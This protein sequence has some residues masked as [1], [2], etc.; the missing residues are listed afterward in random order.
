MELE[1]VEAIED[2]RIV[3]V[4]E[5]YARREGLFILRKVSGEEISKP[6][7]QPYELKTRRE[8]K[9]EE[10]LRFEDFRKP[11]NWRKNQVIS[12]LKDN[13]QWS[14]VSERKRRNMTRKQLADKVGVS[15]NE[16]KLIENGLLPANDFVLVNKIQSTLGINLRKDGNNFTSSARD[17]INLGK[18]MF[19]SSKKEEVK[20]EE[21]I[22]K[23][24]NLDKLELPDI[25]LEEK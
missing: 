7:I 22:E 5:Y 4:T 2:G 20:L 15:E 25:E 16:I 19:E 24:D 13:F 23:K 6:K 21:N 17:K 8:R 3:K 11:L 18:D 10:K 1:Y 14:V 12:E 9:E